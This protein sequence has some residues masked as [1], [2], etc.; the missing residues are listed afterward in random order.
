MGTFTIGQAA[1]ESGTTPRAVRLYESRG[2]VA[3]AERTTSGYRVFTDDDVEALTFIRR[4]RSL[5]LSLDAIAEIMEISQ[6]GIPCCDRT[7]ALLADRLTE[8]DAAITDLELLRQTVVAAQELEVDQ[9]TGAR[10]A[11]IEQAARSDGS[12]RP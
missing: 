7:R 11:V 5:G 6:R 2:L 9:T 10:C 4:A 8:I 3:S 12:F 1:K